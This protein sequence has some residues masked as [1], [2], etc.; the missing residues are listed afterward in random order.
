MTKERK[1]AIK[2]WE[3]VKERIPLWYETYNKDIVCVLKRFKGDFCFRN[4]L[5]WDNN[6]WFCQY[7]CSECDRCPLKSCEYNDPT[8]AWARIV[9][10]ETSL[11]TKLAA[12]DDIIKALGG[13][14]G[15]V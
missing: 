4:K 3:E 7:I 1:L 2:M 11:E 8:T 10:A 6:C 12:C 5:S 14:G 13:L 9:N 15:K